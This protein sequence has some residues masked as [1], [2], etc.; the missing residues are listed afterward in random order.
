MHKTKKIKLQLMQRHRHKK[1]FT[2]LEI[3]ICI[4]IMALAA[5]AM[6]YPLSGLLKEHRFQQGVKQFVT[7]LRE[8]QS[9]ALNYQSDMTLQFYQE[10][11]KIM[12]RGVTD[13]PIFLFKPFEMGNISSLMHARKKAKMPLT[14][15]I[16]PT[17]R[18]EPAGTLTFQSET[19]K[20][21][22]NFET[23]PLITLKESSITIED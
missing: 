23:S 7:H 16:Y 3:M 4:A 15:N 18:I 21:E 5:S 11:G 17:G 13:E 6:I 14:F 10:N 20:I 9:L 12:C 19:K 8:M 1:S 2:L 22:I